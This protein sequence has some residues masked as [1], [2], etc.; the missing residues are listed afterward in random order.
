MRRHDLVVDDE[1]LRFLLFG[2][3]PS[4]HSPDSEGQIMACASKGAFCFRPLSQCLG[5]AVLCQRTLEG[6]ELC[7]NVARHNWVGC[8]PRFAFGYAFDEQK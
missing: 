1:E 7:C 3:H 2:F 8:N 6:M 5:L 4:L